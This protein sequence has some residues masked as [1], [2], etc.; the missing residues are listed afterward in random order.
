MKPL[1]LTV[2][3]PRSPW[4]ALDGLIM[5]PRTIDKMRA[6][7]AGGK[8]GQYTI[9]GTSIRLLDAIGIKEADL[10]AVVQRARSDEEVAE[11]LRAHAN[12]G[13][14]ET[15]N[16]M[17]GERRLQDVDLEDFYKRY[18]ISKELPLDT[19]LFDMLERDDALSFDNI[20]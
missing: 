12:T 18:P 1:D 15:A 7:L 8:L 6:R 14:Y 20:R 3:P 17:L 19:R 10:Q 16:T 5:M 9:E 13:A 4:Q 11:W 2:A